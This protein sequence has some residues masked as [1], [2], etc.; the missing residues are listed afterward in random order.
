M[1]QMLMYLPCLKTCP[2]NQI[3]CFGVSRLPAYR[4]ESYFQDPGECPKLPRGGWN[5]ELGFSEVAH[6][7]KSSHG[8]D[9]GLGPVNTG[10]QVIQRVSGL[11]FPCSLCLVFWNR[12]KAGSV[13]SFSVLSLQRSTEPSLFCTLKSVQIGVLLKLNPTPNTILGCFCL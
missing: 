5:A 1:S 12:A 10:T 8:W 3:S 6:L 9:L 2:E 11:M 7:G 4:Q 13:A